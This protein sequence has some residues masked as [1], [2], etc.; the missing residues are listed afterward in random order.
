MKLPH[1]VKLILF[2]VFFASG[3]CL[4]YSSDEEFI[5]AAAA[6]NISSTVSDGK[7]SI[8]EIVKTAGKNNFQVLILTDRDFMQWEYGLWPFRR[9]IRKTVKSASVFTYGIKRYLQEIEQI[10]KEY[11]DLTIIPALESAPFYYWQ[12]SPFK[13]N[14]KINNWHKHILTIGIENAEDYKYLPSLSNPDGFVL[15]FQ[16]SDLF[17]FWPIV[18][19]IAGYFCL[20]KKQFDY[21]DVQGKR[22]GPGSPA[23][24]VF[25]IMLLACGIL[26]LRNNFPFRGL[27]YDQYH[28]D[29]DVA[30][31]QYLIDYVKERGGLTFWAHPQASN[32]EKIGD[33]SIETK[34]HSQDLL[35]AVGYTGFAVF[36][37]GYERIG[38]PEEIW[39]MILNEY[40]LG[41]RKEPV[42]AIGALQFDRSGD[43]EK[44]MQDL[45]TVLLLRQPGKREVLDA[46][47]SGRM[48]VSRGKDSAQFILDKF[49][50]LDISSGK[51][52][53]L[54]Q[55][56]EIK[57]VPQLRIKGHFSNG[58]NQ[59]CSIKLIRN[60]QVIKIFEV[61]APFDIAFSDEDY[62]GKR[63]T[64]Y[65]IEIGSENLQLISNPIFVEY[66]SLTVDPLIDV[67]E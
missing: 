27:K 58:Q 18:F 36:Y 62:R 41:K 49:S 42:W 25:G 9:L 30:P 19:F 46:L 52:I 61:T 1:Y 53:T 17:L 50:A 6:I 12:G 2:L 67:T 22:L 4:A 54:G 44:L 20:K 11:P 3:I 5:Q 60:G 15:P 16:T 10:G 28:G 40:C 43:L 38:K 51:E 59:A 66:V 21:T 31:Y 26:F 56:I 64:Y 8:P 29:Q 65:R 23:G 39:D 48:Y 32:I 45:R 47:K 35:G 34:D 14:L 33:V 55:Q 24:R 57:Q 37:E 7:L 13:R 63:K